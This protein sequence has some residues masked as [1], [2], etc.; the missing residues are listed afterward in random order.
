[1]ADAAQRGVACAAQELRGEEAEGRAEG[2]ETAEAAEG[3]E[4]GT[5]ERPGEPRSR[6]LGLYAAG[7]IRFQSLRYGRFNMF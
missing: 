3:K 2:T 6:P 7:K 1:M 4:V 5:A